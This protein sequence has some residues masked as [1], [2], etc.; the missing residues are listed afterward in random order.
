ME[1]GGAHTKAESGHSFRG[2]AGGQGAYYYNKEAYI[3]TI[4]K[5]Q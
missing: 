1:H 3:N 4:S 2:G 5:L